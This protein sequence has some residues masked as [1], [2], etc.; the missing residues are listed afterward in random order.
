M[1]RTLTPEEMIDYITL[2]E[3]TPETIRFVARVNAILAQDEEL[4]RRIAA[5]EAVYDTLTLP[6]TVARNLLLSLHRDAGERQQRS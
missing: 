5:L 1:N 2:T 3:K 4:R 6:P